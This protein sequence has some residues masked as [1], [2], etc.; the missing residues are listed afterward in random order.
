MPGIKMGRRLIEEGAPVYILAEIGINHEGDISL[1]KEM[2]A[3]AKDCGADGV[4]FQSFKAEDL[5][6]KAACP[7]YYELFKKVE[8]SKKPN[9]EF[10]DF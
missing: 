9:K 10:F 8:L 2:I 1:A 6:D 5:V 3:A 7:E 4:K